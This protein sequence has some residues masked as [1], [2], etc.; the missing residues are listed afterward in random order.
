MAN[1]KE[2]KDIPIF[3]YGKNDN[4]YS[5]D[6]SEVINFDK[7]KN[8]PIVNHIKIGDDCS[9]E[10]IVG[11]V[12][13]ATRLEFPYLYGDVMLLDNFNFT[14]FKNYQIQCAGFNSEE[15]KLTNVDILAIEL[16]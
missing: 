12:I 13:N 16:E 5:I 6:E 9:D 15:M 14:K 2:I 11:V 1:L 10:K 4:G 7:F 8:I 3:M